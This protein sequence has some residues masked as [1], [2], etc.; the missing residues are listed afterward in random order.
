MYD[1]WFKYHKM[2]GSIVHI[3]EYLQVQKQ[4]KTTRNLSADMHGFLLPAT[5][6]DQFYTTFRNALSM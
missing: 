2:I 1:N 6:L 5:R 4:C 3:R